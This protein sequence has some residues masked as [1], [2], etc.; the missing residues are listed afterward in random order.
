MIQKLKLAESTAH[1]K[2][3]KCN[4]EIKDSIDRFN[5]R[6]NLAEEGSVNW[7]TV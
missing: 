1:S 6:L 4:I 5:I 7:K 3:E 2:N